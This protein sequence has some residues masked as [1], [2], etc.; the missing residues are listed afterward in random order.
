MSFNGFFDTTIIDDNDDDLEV[1]VEYYA[2]YG[3]SGSRDP[4]SPFFGVDSD[5]EV[6]VTKVIHQGK[7]IM[8]TLSEK[9]MEILSI[10]AFDDAFTD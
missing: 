7:C 1:S 6:E 2:N 10:E 5:P 3:S 4:D 9:N 8:D